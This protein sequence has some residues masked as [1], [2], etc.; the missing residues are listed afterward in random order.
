MNSRIKEVSEPIL[1]L[2]HYW[3]ISEKTAINTNV[4]YQFGKIGNSRIDYNGGANPSAAYYQN[5]P[6][7]FLRYDDFEGAYDAENNF[8]NDGQINWNR[9][10]DANRTN[11][12]VG[13]PNAYVL[14]ED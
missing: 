8:V 2:N 5:L 12:S 7:Y 4:S 1:M 14:Y 10:F 3:N 9:V 6:S 13:L 11:N